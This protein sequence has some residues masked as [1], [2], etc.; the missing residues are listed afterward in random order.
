MIFIIPVK[1]AVISPSWEKFSRLFE[2]C[3]RSVCQQTDQD[4]KVI[5]VCN[6]RPITN[7][8][9]DNIHYVYVDFLPPTPEV[10]QA[11]KGL[12]SPKEADKSKKIL[13]GLDYASQFD[14]THVMVVDADDCI[15]NKIVEYVKRH[16]D[17]EGWYSKMG[18]VYRE[19][20]R[21]IFKK[22]DKFSSL[23]GTSVIV[24]PQYIKGIISA[25]MYFRHP[26]RTLD[27]GIKL[28]PLP[29][30]AAVYTING[31]NYFM[32]ENAVKHFRKDTVTNGFAN[33]VKRIA[34][35]RIWFLTPGVKKRFGLYAVS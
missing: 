25:D 24:K 29:F 9:H 31:E 30:P 22:M 27:N 7:F 33:L 6:E 8:E 4:F 35:Y 1:S 17:V 13:A 12:H 20:S 19:G 32:T 16:S 21:L 3:I 26:L 11:F 23:C 28:K 10:T 15:N 2:R 18:Y 5:V 34:R 14:T